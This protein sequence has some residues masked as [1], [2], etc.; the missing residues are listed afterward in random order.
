MIA[1][2]R[3]A[4]PARR[5][6]NKTGLDP[7]MLFDSQRISI[8]KSKT[9]QVL[10]SLHTCP[11]PEVKRLGKTLRRWREEILAYFTAGGVSNGSR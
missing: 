3:F 1:E 4:R 7:L 8:A 2:R 6:W 5:A 11:I 10:D 9:P